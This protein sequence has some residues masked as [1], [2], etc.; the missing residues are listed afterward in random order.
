MLL[1]QCGQYACSLIETRTGIIIQS[2]FVEFVLSSCYKG[3][4]SVILPRGR[5]I[6]EG[7]SLSDKRAGRSRVH[8]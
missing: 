3:S 7:R 8:F 2:G 5:R 4:T 6:F 1:T